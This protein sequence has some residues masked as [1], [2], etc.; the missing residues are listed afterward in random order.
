MERVIK[1]LTGGLNLLVHSTQLNEDQ[2]QVLENMEVRPTS[3]GDNLTYLA[4]TARFSYKRLNSSDL[5]LAPANLIEFVQRNSGV[6]ITTFT[7]AGLNDGT[8]SGTY[9]G[10]TVLSTY[11]VEIDSSVASP[12]T[13]KWRKDA[14]SYTTGVSITAGVAQTLAE[15]VKITFAAADGHTLGNKWTVN[16]SPSGTKWLVTGG[17]D[18]SANFVVKALRDG[19][20]SPITVKSQVSSNTAICSFMIFNDQL[21]YTNGALAWR[22]WNGLDDVASTYTTITKYAIQHKNKAIYL[23]DVTN[24]IPNKI[25]ISNT[26][27]P[28]TVSASN[29]FLIGDYSDAIVLGIDQRERIVIGKEKSMWL[30]A[31]APTITDSTLLKGEQFKGTISPLGSMYASAGTFIYGD[32]TGIQTLSGLYMEP[33]VLQ[34][35]NQLRGFNNSK[36]ALSFKDE[37][38]L[39]STLSDSGQTRNNRIYLI[40]L[41]D[42]TQKVWQYNLSIGCFCQNIGSLTFG[43]RLKA[44][45][46][47]GTNRY[48]IELDEVSSPQETN[49][50]CVAQTKD[51]MDLENDRIPRLQ[52]VKHVIVDFIA[53]NTSNA[54]TLKIY[55]DGSLKETLPFTPS[56][57]GF[58][59]HMF[60]PRLDLSRGYRISYR[61]EYTQPGSDATRFSILN[62][63]D[64]IIVETR[65]E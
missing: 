42:E 64:E 47:D 30:F 15:G 5:S 48:F 63:S 36:A 22:K 38:L 53:P 12:D 45:E 21:Y 1:S 9:T 6:G 20:T 2:L 8:F 39:I 37:Q 23:N 57:T 27:T 65:V 25:W 14:G 62:Y 19:Q 41:I 49:I 11:E 3:V 34:L 50:S 24:N 55:G 13:F 46:D 26:G 35:I 40:D 32:R 10:S 7:G 43:K 18:G 52:K 54:L 17:W 56:S 33:V 58:N 61:F 4:L 60:K 29:G 44:M 28:E 59:R 16:V 51:W 31:L